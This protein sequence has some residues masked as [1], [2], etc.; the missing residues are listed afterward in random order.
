M[1]PLPAS[2]REW[3]E[4]AVHMFHERVG[5]MTEE[6]GEVP[7]EVKRKAAEDVRRTWADRIAEAEL[8][9]GARPVSEAAARF[10]LFTRGGHGPQPDRF[11]AARWGWTVQQVAR[12]RGAPERHRGKR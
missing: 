7:V 11:Y 4:E 3:P 9:S 8:E 5:M 6:A 12:L 10:D 2:A 1:K